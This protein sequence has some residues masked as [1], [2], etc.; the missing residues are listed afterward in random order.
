METIEILV[1][2][3]IHRIRI[4]MVIENIKIS[5]VKALAICFGGDEGIIAYSVTLWRL[6]GDIIGSQQV[7]ARED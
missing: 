1:M 6:W 7:G 5:I 3:V 2:V 4:P